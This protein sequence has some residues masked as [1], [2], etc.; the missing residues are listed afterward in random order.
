MNIEKR[1]LVLLT[2]VFILAG[3]WG[4]VVSASK[5]AAPGDSSTVIGLLTGTRYPLP[6][7]FYMND[8]MDISEIEILGFQLVNAQGARKAVIRPDGSGYFAKK[9]DPGTYTL[10][11]FRKDRSNY[12]DIKYINIITFN[13]GP[14]ELVNLGTIRLVLDGPPTED[15]F[16][17]GGT[18]RGE[19]L[20]SYRYRR[21]SGN[22]ANSTPLAKFQAKQSKAYARLQNNIREVKNAVTSEPDS[23][24]MI[25]ED[26]SHD[27]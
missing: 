20:Y 18:I 12:K 9:L 3:Y 14:G 24:L 2:A 6:G 16:P 10:R 17:A 13:V 27:S 1:F 23:S 11:R 19:Y 4:P 25:L 15:F 8:M 26:S 21:M 5:A 22:E 7:F